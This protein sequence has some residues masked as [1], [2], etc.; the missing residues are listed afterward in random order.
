MIYKPLGISPE[1]SL[2]STQV[3]HFYA[4]QNGADVLRVHDVAEAKRTIELY[5]ILG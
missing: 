1:A 2:P 5:K 4:L 3:L